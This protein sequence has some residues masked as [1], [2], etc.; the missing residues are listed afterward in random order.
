M[1]T[2]L[3]RTVIIYILISVLLRCMGKRQV[4]E[5]ELSDLVATLLL[6]EVASLPI[7]DPNVPL[8]NALIP[9]LLVL[10][11]EII[12][13]YLKTK[14]SPLKKLL[15]GKPSILIARGHLDQAELER[16][17][18]SIEELIGECRLQ[19]Y[20]DLSDIDYAILEQDGQ[21]SILPRATKQPL[22]AEDV[23]VTV[24]DKGLSHP[25]ILDGRVQD[26]HLAM[27]GLDRRFLEKECARRGRPINEVL[28]MTVDDG[29]GITFIGKE[30]SK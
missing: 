30:K 27:L 12:L 28:L 10:S 6:S 1:I 17:R 4:G 21:L 7:A 23:G 3:F 18:I 22:C 16:M 14:C 11:F 20:A 13:T 29:G 5:L 9:L 26:N 25:V 15:E 19:G 8:L 2:I 24:K